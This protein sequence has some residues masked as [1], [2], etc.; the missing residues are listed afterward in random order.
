[1]AQTLCAGAELGTFFVSVALQNDKKSFGAIKTTNQI[2][3]ACSFYSLLQYFV[4][5]SF[6]Y[7]LALNSC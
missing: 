2:F 7:I 6:L 4:N 1:M 3:M 5:L